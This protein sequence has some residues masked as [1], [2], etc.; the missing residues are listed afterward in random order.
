MEEPEEALLVRYSE[1]GLKGG[2][3]PLF[4]K[5]LVENLRSAFA[6]FGPLHIQRL[7]G[8]MLVRGPVS[9]HDLA[10]V[11]QRVFGVASVSP[12]QC[13]PRGLAGVK[14][15]AV[16]QAKVALQEYLG[17]TDPIPMKVE[18]RRADKSITTPSV[19]IAREIG[20][21]LLQ[22]DSRF[23]VDLHNPEVRVG[24]DLR[25][26]GSFV[27]ATS[28]PGPQ[29]LPVGTTGRAH[30]LLSGGIDSPV[31]AWMS[32][33]RG[34]RVDFVSFYSFPFVGPQT[35]EKIQKLAEHLMRWQPVSALHVV[36]FS[37]YQI[38]IRDHCP[39]AYR[40]VLYR[41]AMQR[42]ASIIARRRKG[43]ALITGESLGQVASQT[44]ANMSLI[45]H[46]STLPVLRPLV[47]FDKLETI[48][49]AR[50]IG[51]F[52]LS[53]LPAPD[54]CTVFQPPKP[55][56]YGRL[57]DVEEAEARI[58]VGTLTHEAVRGTEKIPLTLQP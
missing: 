49:V 31:A 9:A 2:N 30:C 35:K 43:R 1:I 52:D 44:L 28:L 7:R 16:A 41:R 40:T 33:K 47:T 29:G 20:A 48:E 13:L 34:L 14:E 45:E 23:K 24:I 8:R 15:V 55:V 32:M 56:I 37:D 12:A 11:A 46:A 22:L 17:R 19:E 6:E 51:T 39:A 58:H 38:A 27:Y 3:R 5:A 18:V 42:I 10:R 54:C 53:T 4:E 36:P 50:R 57:K 21:A 26:E 25:G